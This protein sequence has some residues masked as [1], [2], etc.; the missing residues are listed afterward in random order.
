MK[1]EGTIGAVAFLAIAGAVGFSLQTGSKPQEGAGQDRGSATGR[2][3]PSITKKPN[4]NGLPSCNS[5][6]EQFE[7]FLEL[8]EE[9]L[10]LPKVA[11]GLARH[12]K[13]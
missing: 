5:L 11:T 6:E 9:D 3:K 7:D 10:I 8:K 2:S 4:H 12:L 1:R 13:A